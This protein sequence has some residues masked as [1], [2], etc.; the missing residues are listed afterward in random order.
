MPKPCCLVMSIFCPSHVDT[1]TQ[2]LDFSNCSGAVG[3]RKSLLAVTGLRSQSVS[4]SV[5]R[6]AGQSASQSVSQSVS[7]S[8]GWLVGWSFR[9]CASW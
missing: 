7:G 6:S 9:K 5:G 1:F 3:K 4:Q 2:N 8:V